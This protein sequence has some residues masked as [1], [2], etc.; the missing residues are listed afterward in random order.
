[1]TAAEKAWETR[2]VNGWVHPLTKAKNL[3]AKRSAA[4]RKAHATRKANGWVHP[5]S[6]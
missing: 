2:R 3:K 1:M 4:A 6:R 5:A